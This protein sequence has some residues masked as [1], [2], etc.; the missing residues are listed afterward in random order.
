[1]IGI[2]APL[3]RGAEA[4]VKN[5]VPPAGQRRKK[6]VLGRVAGVARLRDRLGAVV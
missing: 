4:A 6:K 1:M 5:G 2:V 3:K